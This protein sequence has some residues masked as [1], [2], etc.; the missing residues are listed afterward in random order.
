MSEEKKNY[1]KIFM[2]MIWK[3]LE[4]KGRFTTILGLAIIIAAVVDPLI[5]H[6]QGI[7][8]DNDYMFQVI[9]FV[10]GGIIL[11]ILPSEISISKTDGFKIKD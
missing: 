9:Y 7:T 11:I 3:A 5:K 10:L 2:S 6:N 8:F 1:F 4:E